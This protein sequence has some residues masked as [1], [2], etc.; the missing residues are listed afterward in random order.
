MSTTINFLKNI[1]T[2]SERDYKKEKVYLKYAIIGL[3]VVGIV[4]L[5]AFV[6]QI[7]LVKRLE[8]IEDRIETSNKQL[9]GLADANA[10]QI[11]LKSRLQLIKK[12]LSDRSIAREA[13]QKVFSL[14]IP[15][16]TVSGA[17]F[18]SGNLMQLQTKADDVLSFAN[19]IDYLNQDSDFFLQTVSKGVSRSEDG[20]YQMEIVL[21]LPKES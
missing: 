1:P 15:G 12:S 10:Q 16:V 7:I 21:T 19:L 20:E 6:W 3:I 8:T 9:I 14:N 2:L 17:A 18:E 5:A 13:V 4:M 11:Y